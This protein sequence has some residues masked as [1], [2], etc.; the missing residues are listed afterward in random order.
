MNSPNALTLTVPT[1]ASVA[2]PTGTII[3]IEQGGTGQVSVAGASGVT[4]NSLDGNKK[5]I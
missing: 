2:F 4:I 3:N 5:L 1:D